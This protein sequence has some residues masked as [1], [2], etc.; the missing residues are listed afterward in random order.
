MKWDD[1]FPSDW[2]D[3]TA[4]PPPAGDGVKPILLGVGVRSLRVDLDDWI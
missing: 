3:V 2:S 1:S 4:H